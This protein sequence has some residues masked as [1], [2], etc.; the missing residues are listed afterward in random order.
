MSELKQFGK[1]LRKLINSSKVFSLLHEGDWGAGGCWQLAAALV[2]FMGPP[3]ELVALVS[4]GIVQHVL[5]KFDDMYIDY[6]GAQTARELERNV[7]KDPHY[8]SEVK[9][10]KFTKK[11]QRETAADGYIPCDIGIVKALRS[12]LYRSFPT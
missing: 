7:S 11:L 3:A 1:A 10:V 5:V 8:R 12:E 6:N 4:E 2:E 9:L